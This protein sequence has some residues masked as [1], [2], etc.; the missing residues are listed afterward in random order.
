M[1]R[2]LAMQPANRP[3]QPAI[4]PMQPASLAT[5]MKASQH[6]NTLFH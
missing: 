2:G 5:T 1:K 4:M 3:M 6:F